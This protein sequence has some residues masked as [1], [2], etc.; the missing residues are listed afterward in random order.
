MPVTR[1][2]ATKAA[3]GR[4][5]ASASIPALLI[6]F[7]PM[8]F[9][10][11]AFAQGVSGPVGNPSA[12]PWLNPSLSIPSRVDM[13]I[14]KMTIA[15]EIALVQGNGSSNPYVF[16][17]AENAKLCIPS[18]GYEDGPNG[19]A[20]QLT[21]V[22][23][24][25]AGVSIAATF[26]RSLAMQYGVVIGAEQAAKGSGADLGPTVN[27]DRD[28]RWGRSFESLSEDPKL[29]ADIG[30]A[31]IEGIQTQRVMAQVKHFDAYNEETNR[32][33]QA[34]DVI[35]TNRVLHE[36]YE[37]SFAEAIKTGGAASLMC[38]YSSVNGFYSCQDQS[39]LTGVLR[40]EF[41]FNGLVMS[42]YGAVHDTAAAVA[43]TDSEQPEN[44]YFGAPL[45]AAVQHGTVSRAT[46]NSMVQPILYEMFR[47]GFFNAPPSG[48]VD[49]VA[50]TPAHVSF[51]NTVAEAGTVL[52]KNAGALLP[53]APST[54]I[55]VIGPAAS[56]Q[57][58]S[59]GGGSAHVIPS[60]TVT[61]LMGI[62]SSATGSVTY[63]QGLPND[64]DL[65]PIPAGD[66]STAYGG[67]PYGGSYTATLTAP[68]TGTY[69]IGIT[70]PCGCYTP[71]TVSVGGT[72]LIVNPGTPPVSAYSASIS[73]TK[74]RTYAVAISGETSN[75]SWATPSQL[76]T[77]YAPA[78][79]A[80]TAAQVAVVVVADDTESEATDRPSLSLPSAQDQLIA[81]VAAANPNTVVVVQAGAPIT[82]PWLS[83]VKSVLDTWYPGQTDGTAL[84]DVLYGVTNP[85]GHLPVT[86]PQSL[87]DVPA[88]SVARFP[89]TNN[90]VQYSEGLLVGYRWYDQQGITPLFPFGYGL[91]YTTFKY[92]GLKIADTSVDGTTAVPVTATVTNTGR[93]AGTDVA[94]LYLA[95]P[96][97]T[98]EPPRKLVDFSPVTLD[99]GASKTV[100]FTI[101]PKDEWWWNNNGWDETAG[102]YNVFVGDSS[103]LTGLPLVSSYAM[104]SSIG[105]RRVTVS[106]PGTFSRN[107]AATVGV[108]LTAG[109]TQTLSTV[110]LTLA[111]PP[112]WRSVPLSSNSFADVLPGQAL[113]VQF[114]VTP[115]AG[116]PPENVT[117]YGGAAFADACASTQNASLQD[118]SPA[119]I[120]ASATKST[121][122]APVMRNGGARSTLKP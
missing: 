108:T 1:R 118:A 45:Q 13:L 76:K 18:L 74:G 85:G 5:F 87:A 107:T 113:T 35:V 30:T 92:S 102:S 105:N 38:A 110:R 67:T 91:S 56:S 33:T 39:L 50:T 65:T 71:A 48:N 95:L 89:G 88:A 99:A 115:P 77:Y 120:A 72:A 40:N 54:N 3:R 46:L 42:D 73:L 14:S 80:A 27:I 122:C 81:K 36:I 10:P 114:A 23:Q 68:E 15:D 90:T 62:R 106:A 9:A 25:P 32:N 58:V 19:V 20:D 2:S 63:S 11:M 37:P 111:P 24:L 57:V 93:V 94:Q 83:A 75:L 84:A 44:T 101:Q 121:A 22:T 86:F 109:G 104:A 70:N 31:E 47:F 66:L 97:S 119:L 112:G 8:A 100:S 28:P 96:A 60:S 69:V 21:D 116:A 51:S 34:D 98:G 26:S 4:L 79:A 52:L 49:A 53:L 55:A 103:A 29:S 7:A 6:G 41:G 117:L 43:G 78:V 17:T 16:F 12:C 82:M 59:G 61:P 64:T